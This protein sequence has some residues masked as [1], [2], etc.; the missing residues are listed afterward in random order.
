MGE[1]RSR[2]KW[3][4]DSI[5]F[6]FG[7]EAQVVAERYAVDFDARLLVIDAP[8]GHEI[9][10]ILVSLNED[11][12]LTQQSAM[13][14][15]RPEKLVFEYE[16]LMGLAFAAVREPRSALQL[17]LGGGAMVRF[18]SRYFPHT[19]LTVVE[20]DTTVTALARDYFYVSE[21]VLAADAIQFVAETDQR[22]DVVLVDIYDSGGFARVE[23]GFWESAFGLL[24]PKGCLAVNWA[25][26]DKLELYRTHATHLSR[27]GRA[28]VFATPRGF[29]DNV[30]Q[31]CSA[32]PD[33]S[34]KRLREV[35]A[36]LAKRQRRRDILNR[37]TILDRLP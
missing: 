30:V 24:R 20:H 9:R 22:F 17:G 14:L 34:Q 23:T 29:K 36:P 27:L 28:G 21:P 19:D 18:A 10:R 13:S 35:S 15:L 12:Q 16:R 5:A 31:F 1:R 11:G 26:P 4:R 6:L 32:D 25:D 7:H 2:P 33:F 37:C 3:L 8:H